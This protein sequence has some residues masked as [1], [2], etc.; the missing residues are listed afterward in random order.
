MDTKADIRAVEKAER[1][2]R[3]FLQLTLKEA[4]QSRISLGQ[5]SPMK[6]RLGMEEA[7][8]LADK[9]VDAL[10]DVLS[11]GATVKELK[12]LVAGSLFDW[13]MPKGTPL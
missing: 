12:E 2:R 1:G 9:I 8:E 5:I 3:P 4:G 11:K 7:R 6:L 13:R 10:Q